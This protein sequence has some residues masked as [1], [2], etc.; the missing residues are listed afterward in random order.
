ML[1]TMHNIEEYL[2]SQEIEA[3]L[4]QEVAAFRNQ[5]SVAP[6]VQ[7][8]IATPS[9]PFYGKDTLEMA[10]SAI[11]QGENLLLSGG[12]A[13]GKNVLCETLSWVFGRPSYDISFHVKYR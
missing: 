5:Y 11:L 12:K 2:H 8:R 6:E 1:R 13:T 9:L 10:L 7:E 3:D 4:I